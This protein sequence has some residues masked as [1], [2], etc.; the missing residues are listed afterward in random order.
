M[1]KVC[2]CFCTGWRMG[3]SVA[4]GKGKHQARHRMVPC[5][6]HD[7]PHVHACCMCCCRQGRKV[8]HVSSHFYPHTPSAHAGTRPCTHA[9]AEGAHQ[10]GPAG[11]G[12]AVTASAAA[13]AT[14]AAPAA[15]AWLGARQRSSTWWQQSLFAAWAGVACAGWATQPCAQ[16]QSARTAGWAVA[17]A[18]FQAL[19][20]TPYCMG[21]AL[22]RKPDA[23]GDGVEASAEG[24]SCCTDCAGTQQ[25]GVW[26]GEAPPASTSTRDQCHGWSGG[27]CTAGR[28]GAACRMCGLAWLGMTV[29]LQ[30]GRPGGQ[31]KIL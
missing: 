17:A 14:S 16:G 19:P 18:E 20:C 9:A 12:A 23:P 24:S 28:S 8:R 7:R 27:C 5:S 13:S 15:A 1:L 2:L 21:Q 31:V 3:V 10:Q 6:P 29:H 22:R 30:E 11:G 25:D 26:S 4:M